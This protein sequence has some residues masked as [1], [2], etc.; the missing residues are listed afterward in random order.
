MFLPFSRNVKASYYNPIILNMQN[1]AS[2]FISLFFIKV[3]FTGQRFEMILQQD[4]KI[5]NDN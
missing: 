1:P 2:V 4:T 5:R 3:T